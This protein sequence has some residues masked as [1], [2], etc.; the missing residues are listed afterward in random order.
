MGELPQK[1]QYSRKN[2]HKEKPSL[3]RYSLPVCAK[4]KTK[5]PG[6]KNKKEDVHFP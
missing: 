6:K 3:A 2:T 5:H 1:I 4:N